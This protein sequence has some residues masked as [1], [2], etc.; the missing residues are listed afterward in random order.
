MYTCSDVNVFPCDHTIGQFCTRNNLWMIIPGVGCIG[1]GSWTKL[2]YKLQTIS[3]KSWKSPLRFWKHLL[4]CCHKATAESP[5]Q[6]YVFKKFHVDGGFGSHKIPFFSWRLLQFHTTTCT[7][8]GNSAR[9]IR[10]GGLADP[11]A[12][13]SFLAGVRG[14]V[15]V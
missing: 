7:F 10:R 14:S 4:C 6:M 13:F 9:F 3:C 1:K 8:T 12:S 15:S 11:A 2:Q 5:G